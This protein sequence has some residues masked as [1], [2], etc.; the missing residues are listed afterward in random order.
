MRYRRRE[1]HPDADFAALVDLLL[2]RFAGD[3]I[4]VVF[5]GDLLDFDAPWVKGGR[6]SFDE[7][8][9]NAAGCA[10]HAGRLI[11]DH[12]GWFGAVAKLLLHGHRVLFMCGNHDIELYFPEAQTAIRERIVA[13]WRRARDASPEDVALAAPTPDLAIERIRFRTWFHVTETQIYLEHG[14]QYDH[15]NGVRYAAI[16]LTK[17]RSRIHPLFGK[18]AFKRTGARMGYFNPY[19]EETFYMGL[20]G[21]ARH[22]AQAYLFSNRHIFRTWLFGMLRTVFEIWHHRH[23]EDW[24]DEAVRLTERE[25]GASKEAILATM[26]LAI[27]PGERKMLPILREAWLDRTGLFAFLALAIGGTWLIGGQTAGLIAIGAAVFL[28]VLYELLTPKPDLRTYDQ[29]PPTVRKIWDIHRV[30]GICM[31]HTHRPFAFWED[32]RFYGNSGAWCP[33]FRDRECTQP[34]LSGRPF[35]MLWN[36]RDH[37]AG[38]LYWLRNGKLVAEPE[39]VRLP[40]YDAG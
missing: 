39:G 20:F 34:V 12:P 23:S 4:E 36:E 32:G 28:F 33:A 27:E 26:D 9:L 30:S 35:L 22:F 21:Y 6:S 19:Y 8:P 16:P 14:S 13:L 1:H 37:L 7:F 2:A 40:G 24:T 18:Q 11:D 10:E 5:N 38:G 3:Q 17:D 25:T 31:G 29:A 15:L